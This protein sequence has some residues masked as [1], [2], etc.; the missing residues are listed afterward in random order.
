MTVKSRKKDGLS[1]GTSELLIIETNLT[2]FSS[3]SWVLDSSLSAYLC[4]SM[5]DLEE[6]RRLREGKITLWVGNGARVAAVTIES[7]PLRLSLGP[8]LLLKDCYYIPVASRNLISIS[9]L[10][11]NN[12]NFY[13]NKD[14][15]SIYFR[16]KIIAYTFLINDLYHLHMDMSVNINEQI[17]NVIRSKRPIDRISQK[18]LWLG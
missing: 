11:Q 17:V 3:S 6:V 13:F 5:Q 18:Y 9:V 15:C 12:Y 16:N 2:I 7:Y 1:K 4:T 14:M 8:S 10:A